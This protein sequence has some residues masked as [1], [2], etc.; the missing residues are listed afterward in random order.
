MADPLTPAQLLAALPQREPFR[1]VDEIVA[2]DDDRIVATFR[3]RA[4]ADFYRG[5]FPGRPVTPG[6]L[7]LEAMAQAGVAAHGVYLL[8][9]EA[10]GALESGKLV[11]LFTEAQVE[12]AAPVPPGARI[13]VTGRKLWF[14][15]RKLRSRVEARLE[16]GTL[17]AL[18]ELAGLASAS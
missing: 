8:A 5:H 7:L 6:V 18:A 14:R 1:F 3:F 13:V 11:T 10:P 4:D 9:R 2:V 17:V 16:D 12:F 15:R